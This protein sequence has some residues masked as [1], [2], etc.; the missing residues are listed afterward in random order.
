M[1]SLWSY[2]KEKT[3]PSKAEK[4][5]CLQRLWYRLSG[6][7]LPEVLQNIP[8]SF[9][10]EPHSLGQTT[11]NVQFSTLAVF[12]PPRITPFLRLAVNVNGLNPK[13]FGHIWSGTSYLLCE[14]TCWA[15]GVLQL[16]AAAELSGAACS[17]TARD[18]FSKRMYL[19]FTVYFC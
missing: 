11:V 9:P 18:D 8:Q 10:E 5:G 6:T 4:S 1:C 19:P 3:I 13:C 17:Q 15:S 14:R 7:K 2:F 12:I 16:G